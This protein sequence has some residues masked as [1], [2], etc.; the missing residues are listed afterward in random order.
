MVHDSCSEKSNAAVVP[1]EQSTMSSSLSTTAVSTVLL[2]GF[3]VD[4]TFPVN[5]QLLVPA[6]LSN[7][8]P[9]SDILSSV[10]SLPVQTVNWSPASHTLFSVLSSVSTARVPPGPL[11]SIP[12]R[13]ALTVMVSV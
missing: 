1:D 4:F 9:F 2:L 3:E 6:P 8:K 13:L 12:S 11:T 7:V 5:V 10:N